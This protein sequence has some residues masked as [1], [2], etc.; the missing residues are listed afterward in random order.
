[1]AG[2]GTNVLDQT[3]VGHGV[4][5]LEPPLPK[6]RRVQSAEAAQPRPDAGRR[7]TVDDTPLVLGAVQML[8]GSIDMPAWPMAG[9]KWHHE[10]DP[11][12][13]RRHAGTFTCAEVLRTSDLI[14]RAFSGNSRKT[15][16]TLNGRLMASP[17]WIPCR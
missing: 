2:V 10:P 5:V 9:H 17:N 16:P 7:R 15:W 14:V 3:R 13:R 11:P 12:E 1:M 4:G 8:P 6:L